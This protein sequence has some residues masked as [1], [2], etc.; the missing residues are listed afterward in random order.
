MISL[1]GSK[2]PSFAIARPVS[3]HILNGGFASLNFPLVRGTN[4]EGDAVTS[5]IPKMEPNETSHAEIKR[6]YELQRSHENVV[7]KSSADERRQKLQKLLDVYVAHREH[8]RKAAFMDKGNHFAETDLTEVF[9]VS[10]A[11]KNACSDVSKWMKPQKVSTPLALLG[12][13]S[14]IHHEPKGVCLIIAPWNFPFNLTFG[15]LIS[16]IA[17]GN[18]AMIKP[19]EMTPHC[20]AVIRKIVGQVFDEKEVA[21]VEGAIGTSQSLLAQPFNHIFFTGSPTTGKIVMEAAS[22]HL[23]SV[24]LELGGKSPVVVDE[25]ANI[26]TAAKRI[27]WAKTLNN[28]QICIAPD[29]V[30]VHETK[31]EEFI[32]KFAFYIKQ[33]FG[34]DA[35]KSESF[36]RIISGKHHSRLGGLVND[37][38]KLGATVEHGGSSDA[39]QNFYFEPTVM[40][41][42]EPKSKVMQEE[43][44]GPVLPVL[45][46]KSLDE[47]I[48]AIKAGE[49][50]L[51][52]YIFSNNDTNSQLVIDGTRAGATVINHCLVHFFNGNLPFGGSNF[53]G[54][55][56]SHG[57][58]GFREFSNERAVLK[59]VLPVSGID[60]MMPP[61]NSL[62]QRLADM[63]IKF[64]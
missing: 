34:E 57:I 45:S 55:G 33:F 22:K 13:R 12:T 5:T 58:H 35:S 28:G 3:Q 6:I 54:T 42:L 17:A 36:S 27:A 24:T 8:I 26:D 11:L 31:K 40:S 62:K 30:Y 52:V 10:H 50:P 46:F 7:A 2:L 64:F 51:V 63:A 56:K 14:W 1:A 49:K 59:Q 48:A 43:I 15:P 61:Y 38:K 32:A 23:A 41:G 21:V 4:D 18:C 39:S 47:P 25:T 53:S 60:L 37:A 44:F 16:A 29:H 20:N 9:G 19:S